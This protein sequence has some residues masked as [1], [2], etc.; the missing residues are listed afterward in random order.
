MVSGRGTTVM[1]LADRI[2]RDQLPLTIVLVAASRPGVPAIDAAAKRGLPTT[3]IARE[4]ATPGG[5]IDDAIDRALTTARPDLICL[6][7]YLRLFRVGPWVGRVI[8]IHPGPLPAFGGRGMYGT[9]VH[10]AVIDASLAETRICVHLVDAEYDR[11]PIIAEQRVMVLPADTPESLEARVRLAEYELLPQVLRRIATGEIDLN[12]I[13]AR[14]GRA[15]LS[16]R[17]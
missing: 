6:C 10:R 12:E 8:N 5:A 15:D 3:V 4:G 16:S 7:G 11:G 14:A 1:N 2:E 17:A 9:R 13:A